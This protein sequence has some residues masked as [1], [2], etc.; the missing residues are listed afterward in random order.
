MADNGHAHNAH[1]NSEHQTIC[2]CFSLSELALGLSWQT[3]IAG[4]LHLQCGAL[5]GAPYNGRLRC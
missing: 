3:M 2:V 1:A 4:S 5:P